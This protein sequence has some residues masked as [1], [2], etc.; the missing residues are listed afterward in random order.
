MAS[1]ERSPSIP[2]DFGLDFRFLLPLEN[3]TTDFFKEEDDVPTVDV[4]GGEVETP[5]VTT[6]GEDLS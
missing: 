5:R 2:E 3:V 6:R 1:D 4:G